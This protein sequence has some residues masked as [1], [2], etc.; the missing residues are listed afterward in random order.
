MNGV[1]IPEDMT[2]Y[3]VH[4]SLLLH[5][6]KTDPLSYVFHFSL[7]CE[8]EISVCILACM[9]QTC[10]MSAHVLVRVCRRLPLLQW[11]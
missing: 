4:M 9:N 6:H 10:R 11:L 1:R 8:C 3:G 7:M 5:M 2:K